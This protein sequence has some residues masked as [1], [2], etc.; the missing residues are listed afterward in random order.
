[1][2]I[3]IDNTKLNNLIVNNYTTIV[4][5]VC[6]TCNQNKLLKEYYKD[7]SKFDGLIYNC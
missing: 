4:L 5:K 7:K 6:S 2:S 3:N 1:M